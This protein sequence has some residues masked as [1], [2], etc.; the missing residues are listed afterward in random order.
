MNR[1]LTSLSKKDMLT[2]DERFY[3]LLLSNANNILVE[4]KLAILKETVPSVRRVAVLWSPLTKN[5]PI[6]LKALETFAPELGL[7]LIPVAFAKATDF[8]QPF[9]AIIGSNPDALMILSWSLTNSFCE[10][11]AK[12]AVENRLPTNYSNRRHVL[13][14]GL[15]S[16]GVNVPR[17][18]STCSHLC[19]Q[20]SER[21]EPI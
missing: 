1:E 21:F 15:L 14:G 16:Y 10:Q 18:V 3:L 9:S 13:A 11:I 17:H 6:Q 19:R 2:A 4:K 20:N 8:D 12:R 5:G 7:T